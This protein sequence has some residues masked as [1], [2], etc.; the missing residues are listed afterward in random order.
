M[1]ARLYSFLCFPM[2]HLI[3]YT[4]GR[5]AIWAN[6][7][8]SYVPLDQFPLSLLLLSLVCLRRFDILGLLV[9]SCSTSAPQL[10]FVIPA[11]YLAFKK[12][13]KFVKFLFGLSVGLLYSFYNHSLVIPLIFCKD[14]FGLAIYYT[15]I[16]R[17]PH[18]LEDQ[19]I[20]YREKTLI[21]FIDSLLVPQIFN[22]QA[23]WKL[24]AFLACLLVRVRYPILLAY[25]TCVYL[26]PLDLLHNAPATILII[27]SYK[28]YTG[29]FERQEENIRNFIRKMRMYQKVNQDMDYEQPPAKFIDRNRCTGWHF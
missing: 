26:N 7:L 10:L 27:K 3:L 9:G 28:G 25:L 21:V 15:L 8:L 6:L 19:W 11:V 16:E 14:L 22:P 13:I 2:L 23:D 1:Q 4:I 20:D 5:R 12:Q 29:Q 18:M 24:L 17:W